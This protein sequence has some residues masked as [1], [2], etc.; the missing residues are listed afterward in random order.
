M[1][2]YKS[3]AGE[4]QKVY[5]E[6]ITKGRALNL[7]NP[8]LVK[9]CAEGGKALIIV[10]VQNDFCPGGPM[11][12]EE[13]DEVVAVINDLRERATWDNVILTQDW[14]PKAH[15][16]FYVNHQ[17][18]KAF[19]E[20]QIPQT[21]HKQMLWPTHCVEGE[22]GSEL[23]PQLLISPTDLFIKKGFLTLYDSYSGFG[24]INGIGDTG[25]RSLLH[26][27]NV[28]EVYITGLAFD[29]CVGSTAM[30]C[31]KYGFR[32]HVVM[33]A[34]KSITVEGARIMR[35]DLTHLGVEFV[36]ADEIEYYLYYN[37]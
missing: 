9:R 12:V 7:Q 25:L 13:G 17:E 3:L 22:T 30:D 26:Q 8:Y 23:H 36:N 4:D 19:Q 37:F 6:E 21:G 10:D 27:L 33:D 32:T 15:K 24:G 14:H 35:D 34:T 1:K 11:A 29:Y 16:S 28:K 31:A 2:V 20:I 5:E 18:R